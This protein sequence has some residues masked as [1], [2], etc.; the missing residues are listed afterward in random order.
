MEAIKLK[1]WI[2]PNGQIH[3]NDEIALPIGDVE[4]VM[5]K[6]SSNAPTA[7]KRQVKTKT[8]VKAFQDLFD[9]IEPIAEDFNVDAARWEALKEK[10]EL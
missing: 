4:L 1:G 9:G 8:S 5:W 7:P 3:I 6:I 10:Y 2:D